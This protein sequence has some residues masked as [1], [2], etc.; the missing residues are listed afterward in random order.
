MGEAGMIFYTLFPDAE[1]VAL[2]R[3]VGFLCCF[4]DDDIELLLNNILC[5]YVA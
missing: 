2:I 5:M 4:E 3:F 1:I